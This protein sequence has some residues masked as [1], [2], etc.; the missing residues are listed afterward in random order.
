VSVQD[1]FVESTS[2][3]D[4]VL[5]VAD[6]LECQTLILYPQDLEGASTVRRFRVAAFADVARLMEK[7][8]EVPCPANAHNP[9]PSLF[10]EL[11][12]YPLAAAH[13]P[14]ETLLAL[15]GGIIL[16]QEA[17]LASVLMAELDRIFRKGPRRLTPI[18]RNLERLKY[19]QRLE[20]SAREDVLGSYLRSSLA[21][22]LLGVYFRFRDRWY[23][24]A[25]QSL[26]WLRTNDPYAYEEFQSVYKSV[27]THAQLERLLAH[28]LS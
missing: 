8:V 24:G 12:I 4:F 14:D 20:E 15:R 16:R 13:S 22:D 17:K 19:F 26:S 2:V 10:C 3:Q 5:R 25:Q 1:F 7:V 6:E 18:E 28:V 21:L 23:L 9:L 11:K 27:P